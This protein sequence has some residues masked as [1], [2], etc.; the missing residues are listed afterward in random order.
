MNEIKTAAERARNALIGIPLCD[1]T[2]SITGGRHVA[3]C[4]RPLVMKRVAAA[5]TEAV[6]AL[7][8][9]MSIPAPADEEMKAG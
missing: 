3:G 5:I 4:N 9:A 7:A 1:C 6:A 2:A 8:A